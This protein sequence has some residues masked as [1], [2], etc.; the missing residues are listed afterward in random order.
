MVAWSKVAIG[1]T[2]ILLT[3]LSFKKE[4][5]MLPI[6]KIKPYFQWQPSTLSKV[7][8]GGTAILVTVLSFTKK[9]GSGLNVVWDLDDTLIKSVHLETYEGLM[10]FRCLIA[11]D[12]SQMR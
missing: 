11:P 1:G 6:S 2:A 8:I 10:I 9:V 12:D 4:Q 5:T 7:A 3:V